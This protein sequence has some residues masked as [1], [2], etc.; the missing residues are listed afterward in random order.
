MLAG[1][2]RRALRNNPRLK[3]LIIV[4]ILLITVVF[5]S[6]FS[7]SRGVLEEPKVYVP[8][9]PQVEKQVKNSR[10]AAKII[11]VV[12]KFYYNAWL[13]DR[14]RRNGGWKNVLPLMTE[15]YAAKV[16]NEQPVQDAISLGSIA[17]AVKKV[18]LVKEKSRIFDLQ[19]G[20]KGKDK[21]KT[22][23]L[24]DVWF[25]VDQEMTKDYYLHQQMII[26]LKK[27]DGEWKIYNIFV[28]AA[29]EEPAELL[30]G[31]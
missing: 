21:N 25:L 30:P 16:T 23:L 14:A 22:L 27:V 15:K 31:E 8:V 12:Q 19:I 24:A 7:S 26:Y 4:F 17:N 2:I 1:K 29:E 3:R 6:V 13:S 10:D 28:Y 5:L 11:E 20:K 9:D 18:S